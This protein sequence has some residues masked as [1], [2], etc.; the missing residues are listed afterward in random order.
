METFIS[1]IPTLG[2]PIMACVGV[3]W[4]CYWL[5]NRHSE[6]MAKVQKRCQ[7]REDK[8]YAE[9]EENRKINSEALATISK[10]VEKL[11]GI[12]EDVK[13]IKTDVVVLMAQK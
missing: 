2:F 7:E 11:D 6:D 10:Y 3:G 5:T 8:L 9:I 13:E 4:Y 12:Q 1:M